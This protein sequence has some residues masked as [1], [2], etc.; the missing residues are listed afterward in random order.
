MVTSLAHVRAL[1][2]AEPSTGEDPGSTTGS[3]RRLCRAASRSLAATGA[4]VS[5]MMEPGSPS[6][7]AASD[8]TSELIEELQFTVGDGPCLEAY[9]SRRPVLV[10][11]LTDVDAFRWPAYAAA[12]VEL[13]VCAV[14]AFPLQVGAVRLGVLDVY[15]VAPGPLTDEALS[16]ASTFADV[17]L[18]TV[19]D[20]QAR[21]E[22]GRPAA[23]IDE[24][25]E[26]RAQVHQ[27][28][29]MVMV[30]L[31]V[32]LEEAMVR[33]RAHAYASDRRL[34]D[35]ARDVVSRKMVMER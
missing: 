34:S 17:A 29:G 13:G 1:I 23:G 18:I 4:G 11:D 6:V 22:P 12:A 26:N 32:S 5:L 31:G 19:L 16:L 28:Q 9:E 25:M 20:A 27:A 10:P 15:R 14:F 2:G 35:V 7:A 33:L 3:L 24:S 30:Q 8:G 21:A